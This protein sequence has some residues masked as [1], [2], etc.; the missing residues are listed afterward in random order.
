MPS[1]ELPYTLYLEI[2]RLEKEADAKRMKLAAINVVFLGA[3]WSF[4]MIEATTLMLHA[5]ISEYIA[6]DLHS[7]FHPEG[8][9][10]IA[11]F[12]LFA[13]LEKIVDTM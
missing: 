4:E 1:K 3:V 10:H 12:K 9:D 8:L 5:C 7:N 11:G 13:V 2:K 6:V